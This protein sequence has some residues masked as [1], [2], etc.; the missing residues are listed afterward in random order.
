MTGKSQSTVNKNSNDSSDSRVRNLIKNFFSG[1]F[2]PIFLLIV[3][4]LAISFLTR[5]ALLIK[6]GRGFDWT[7]KNLTGTLAIG[8]FFDLAMTTYL[9]I[10]F[11]FQ[12]WLT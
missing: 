8:A 6:T 10:P 12:V 5:L 11:V 2:S 4:V 9:I 3:L 1:K 7:E